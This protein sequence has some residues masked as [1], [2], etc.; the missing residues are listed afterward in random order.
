MNDLFLRTSLSMF[1]AEVFPLCG[2]NP[3]GRM[4]YELQGVDSDGMLEGRKNGV[5]RTG[6]LCLYP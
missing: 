5:W 2:G 1:P 6:A 4:L 3:G